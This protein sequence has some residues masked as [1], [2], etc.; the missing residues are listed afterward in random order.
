MVRLVQQIT[1][2]YGRLLAYSA[3]RFLALNAD[4]HQVIMQ[5]TSL[6]GKIQL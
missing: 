6:Q 3:D 4:K 5:I 2:V 1:I